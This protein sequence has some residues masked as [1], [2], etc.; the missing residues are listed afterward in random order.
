M[1]S[2]LRTLNNKNTQHAM[3]VSREMGILKKQLKRN[4][5]DENLYNKSEKYL[6]SSLVD[7]T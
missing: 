3:D 7:L 5:R 2:V 6:M 4:A 1:I